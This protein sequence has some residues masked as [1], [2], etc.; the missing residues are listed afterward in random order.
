MLRVMHP[1]ACVQDNMIN[2]YIQHVQTVA[3]AS[4]LVSDTYTALALTA[5]RL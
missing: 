4:A 5:V 1:F 2:L 3:D